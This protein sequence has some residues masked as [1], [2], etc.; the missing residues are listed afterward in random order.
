MGQRLGL[1]DDDRADPDVLAYLEAEN[2]W[3]EQVM[4]PTEPLQ[5]ALDVE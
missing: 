2:A 5:E 1:R 4:K 3:F